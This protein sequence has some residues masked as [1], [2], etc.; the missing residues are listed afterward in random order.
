MQILE[1]VL[2]FFI[3]IRIRKPININLSKFIFIAIHFKRV[4]PIIN[5]ILLKLN[6]FFSTIIQHTTPSFTI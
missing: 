5:I 4:N 1:F 3:K 2:L 6:M